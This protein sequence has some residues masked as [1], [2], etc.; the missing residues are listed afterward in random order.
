[1]TIRH[2]ERNL[3]SFFC[4]SFLLAFRHAYKARGR[5]LLDLRARGGVEVQRDPKALPPR[6]IA[7]P[8]DRRI[9]AP[10]LCTARPMR[11]RSVKVLQ[12]ESIK[13]L[14]AMISS[15]RLRVDGECEFGR[16]SQSEQS[17]AAKD[18]GSDV[19]KGF[20]GMRCDE[21]G[22][23]G[24]GELYAGEEVGGWDRRD[25]D[26]GGGV[27]EAGGVEIGTKYVDLLIWSTESWRLNC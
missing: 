27:G 9:V 25:R 12:H 7:P 4:L 15:A 5:E 24:H 10:N 22:V 13:R 19:E 23:A 21:G 2:N 11:R 1:M 8:Y 16:C 20:G 6:S 14:D 3:L 26:V 17:A 18:E